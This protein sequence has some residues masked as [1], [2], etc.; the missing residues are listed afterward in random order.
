MNHNSKQILD[1]ALNGTTDDDESSKR[2]GEAPPNRTV[3]KESSK[4]F[5]FLPGEYRTSESIYCRV[6]VSPVGKRK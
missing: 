1:F 2:H 3:V 4:S 6:A 5:I